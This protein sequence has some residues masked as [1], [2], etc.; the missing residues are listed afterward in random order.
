MRKL[1]SSFDGEIKQKENELLMKENKLQKA[2]IIEQNLSIYLQ[3]TLLIFFCVVLG[4][5]FYIQLK[6]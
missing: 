1:Q 5:M 4:L 3:V 2:I 6:T